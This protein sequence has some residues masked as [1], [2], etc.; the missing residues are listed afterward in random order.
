[1]FDPSKCIVCKAPITPEKFPFCDPCDSAPDNHE[2][3][4]AA[5]DAL[6]KAADDKITARR[7]INAMRPGKSK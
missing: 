1:M 6:S 7:F 5:L 3:V 2:Q 4:L